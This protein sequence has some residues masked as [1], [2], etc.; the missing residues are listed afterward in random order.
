MGIFFLSWHQY[1]LMLLDYSRRLPSCC[2][3]SW[4]TTTFH[5]EPNM[6]HQHTAYSTFEDRA[7]AAAGSGL[8]NSLPSHLKE[9][10]LS[11]NKFQ[12]VAKDIFVWIVEPRRNA[13]YFNC[14]L[15]ITL[16]TYLVTYWYWTKKHTSVVMK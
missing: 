14:A 9:A 15:K 8:W 11:Y 4:A 16:L 3:C 2:R 10:D 6:H 12:M 5:N 1:D 7:F 13:N